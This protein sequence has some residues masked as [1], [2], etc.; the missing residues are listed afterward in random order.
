LTISAHNEILNPALRHIAG[1]K[2]KEKLRKLLLRKVQINS[3]QLQKNIAAAAMRLFPS[4]N[5]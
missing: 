1:G 5:K 4:A 2:T 3:V